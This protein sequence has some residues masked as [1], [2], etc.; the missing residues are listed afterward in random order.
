MRP[1]ANLP[2]TYETTNKTNKPN[3][4]I[5]SSGGIVFNRKKMRTHRPFVLAIFVLAFLVYAN[6]I[7]N[8]FNFDDTTIIKNNSLV[9]LSNLPKIFVSNYWANTPY[10]KGVLLYRPLP[11]AT[12]ALDRAL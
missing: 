3:T 4:I 10:E 2:R 8:D 1:Q 9:R 5:D 12:F 6:S 11:V 7:R